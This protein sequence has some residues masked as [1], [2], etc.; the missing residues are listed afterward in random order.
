VARLGLPARDLRRVAPRLTELIQRFVPTARRLEPVVRDLRG[1]LPELRE[2]VA[3]IPALE[4]DSVPALQSTTVTLRDAMPVFQGLRPYAPDLISGLFNGFGGATGGY[5][6]ANG[7]FA[8]IFLE[9]S[10]TV[11]TPLTGLFPPG[12]PGL[13]GLRTG[14]HSRC[15]GAAAEPHPDGS[16]PW[17]PDASLCDPGQ[18]KR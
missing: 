10:P 6:D 16:N 3:G 13:S 4:R 5:Y 7:H 12:I 11:G 14:L 15:P 17:I 1:V 18:S 2:G 9:A 8:R